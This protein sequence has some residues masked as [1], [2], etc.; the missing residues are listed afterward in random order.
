MMVLA[1]VLECLQERW[2]NSLIL[3]LFYKNQN[4]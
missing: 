4:L 3:N 1:L 2:L